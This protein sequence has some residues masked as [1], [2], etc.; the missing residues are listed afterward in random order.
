MTGLVILCISR[1]CN[2]ELSFA[3]RFL[4]N[5]TKNFSF[6]PHT[7]LFR[8]FQERSIETQIENL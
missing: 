2:Y 4:E 1:G 6:P 5:G 3:I 8:L 7:S